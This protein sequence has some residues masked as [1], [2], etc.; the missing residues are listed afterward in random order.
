MRNRPRPIRLSLAARR[1]R[2]APRQSFPPLLTLTH[3]RSKGLGYE[4]A[5]SPNALKV[6]HEDS[7]SL[8][9]ELDTKGFVEKLI[10]GDL[11]VWV[12]GAPADE[13]SPQQLLDNRLHDLGSEI[14]GLKR[15]D[16]ASDRLLGANI[17][18]QDGIGGPYEGSFKQGPG[19]HVF[20]EIQAARLGDLSAVISVATTNKPETPAA[21]LLGVCGRR[22]AVQVA[23]SVINTFK[24]PS[25]RP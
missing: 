21:A 1:R 10:Y 8:K 22:C 9:L 15:D 19:P 24:W 6:A 20:V 5:Y 12:Q 17:G 7:R 2:P 13:S 16:R 18:Y 3:W 4:L 25:D 14:M 11:F 23:D